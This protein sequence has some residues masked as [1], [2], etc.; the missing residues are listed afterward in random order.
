MKRSLSGRC[1]R[2]SLAVL[3]F[4][5]STSALAQAS[6]PADTWQFEVT[7][8][9]WAAGMSGWGRIG[10]RTPTVKFDTSF[11]DVWRNLDVGA[12]GTIEAR[13]GRWGV[14]FDAMYVKLG[15]DSEPLA[16]GELGTAKLKVSQT[17]L[18]LASAYR[19]VDDRVMPIDVLGGA[20]YTYLDG[21]L[22]FSR[23]PRL[24]N[25]IDRSNNVSWVDGFLGVRARYYLTD[26]WSV[27]GY[28]DAGTGG[29]K[30]SWQLIAGTNY[31]FTKSVVG[32]FGYRIIS[33]KYESNNFLYQ[34]K[35]EGLYL[36]VGMKF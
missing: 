1:A 31:D 22:S 19:V 35:T 16:G 13:K 20:R 17:I 7:P 15:Q 23:S 32:K 29:T 8:Y 18:Q 30:Y 10:A 21:E 33:M 27:L 4:A 5:A 25:G 3:A 24:P 34:V 9:F 11:S 36:G 28:A 26:K 12:M 14:L 6:P 2:P